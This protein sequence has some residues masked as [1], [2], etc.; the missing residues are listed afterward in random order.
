MPWSPESIESGL[1]RMTPILH[2]LGLSTPFLRAGGLVAGE[3]DWDDGVVQAR[4]QSRMTYWEE[5]L[6][7]EG[8]QVARI[9]ELRSHLED[10]DLREALFE[11][12][13]WGLYGS[14]G[15][16]RFERADDLLR[17]RIRI[18]DL[19]PAQIDPSADHDWLVPH[20]RDALFQGTHQN[21]WHFMVLALA[22]LHR[23]DAV[24]VDAWVRQVAAHV[25]QCPRLPDG[26]NDETVSNAI[27]RPSN[28]SWAHYGYV[29]TRLRYLVLTYAVMADHP[30]LSV[31]AHGVVQRSI[32]AH[33][34][35]LH[36]LGPAAYKDNLLTA[37]G[38]ALYLVA[39][40]LPGPRKSESWLA[41]MWPRLCD[42]MGRELL[43]DGCH[44][45]RSFS[46]HVTF[47]ERPL[48]MVA[49]AR[50]LG[51]HSDLPDRF[52]TLT[53]RS[54]EAFVQAS[55][56]IRSTPGINDDWTVA[57]ERHGLLRLLSS[58]FG[59][60]DWLYLSTDGRSGSAPEARSA[61]L[62]DAGLVAMRSDWSRE[63]RYLFFNASPDG[64]HHHPDPLSVQIWAGGRRLLADPGVGH[65][66]TG[67][68]EIA[69]QSCWHNCPTLG[70][71]PIPNNANPRIL[72]WTTTDELDLAVA[73]IR[74]QSPEGSNDVVFRRHVIFVDRSGWLIW[75]TFSGVPDGQEVWENLH[76]PTLSVDASGDGA[77]IHTRMPGD[78]NLAIYTVADRWGLEAEEAQ[79]WLAYGAQGTPT[80][81]LHF[82]ADAQAASEGFAALLVPYSGDAP[83]PDAG[84]DAVRGK[85][86]GG[87][88]FRFRIGG[89]SRRI[90]TEPIP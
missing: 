13:A 85:P 44:N 36:D 63:G 43:P 45:H 84:I 25:D 12:A 3:D 69:R 52:L 75:D 31:A 38:K 24:W 34:R 11:Y 74:F 77:Q 41:S 51:R 87:I 86:D 61:L 80:Q 14:D 64:G 15:S 10:S 16:F 65:Y 26:H 9:T 68:R 72:T 70:E 28:V 59:R 90:T 29:A 60:E 66:Y 1:V 67:E 5:V 81:L 20:P 58:A 55:T 62:P 54:A 8:E 19:E 18:L 6:L 78:P 49:L 4:W 83:P 73:E 22:H 35:H 56:P 7:G 79:I 48:A 76:F 21:A 30:A 47:I 2:E 82:K 53:R 88:E 32:A 89:R 39:T 17:G 42:G 50:T 27:E 33:A 71:T 23:P 40:L 57:L 37:A 46:Y